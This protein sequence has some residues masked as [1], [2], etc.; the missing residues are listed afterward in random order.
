MRKDSIIFRISQSIKLSSSVSPD[1]IESVFKNEK[2]SFY[3][4]LITSLI[5]ASGDNLSNFSSAIGIEK[6]VFEN[7]RSKSSKHRREISFF[8]TMRVLV[9]LNL[10]QTHSE[11]LMTEC[12]CAIPD[13]LPRDKA[14]R[15]I[16]FTQHLNNEE[17]R[18]R[19]RCLELVESNF[20]NLNFDFLSAIKKI[21]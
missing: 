5:K 1:K 13:K 4:D 15:A 16:V 20:T 12:H 18:L 10:D 19:L 8:E 7:V 2:N 17:K 3:G 11:R 14:L 21:K 9:A 6:K